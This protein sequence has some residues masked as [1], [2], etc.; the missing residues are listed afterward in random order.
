MVAFLKNFVCLG[1]IILALLGIGRVKDE[2]NFS[3]NRWMSLL[4]DDAYISEITIPGTHDTCALYEPWS[5]VVKCQTYSLRD[6]L[7]MGVRFLDIRGRVNFSKINIYH[8]ITYQCIDFKKVAKVCAEFLA[9]NPG[10]TIIMSIKSEGEAS[11]KFGELIDSAI[12]SQPDIWYLENRLPTLGEVRGKIVLFNRYTGD[13]EKGLY[14]Y[15][16]NS[17]P[18]ETI[19]NGSYSIHIQDN[20]S[21]SENS[22]KWE[23]MTAMYEESK[24]NADSENL[25]INF[26]SGVNNTD[27][28]IIAFKEYINPKLC[29]YFSAAEPA[30]YGVVIMD[31]ATPEMCKLMLEK[32]F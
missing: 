18:A 32:N 8:G 9:D 25:Y 24:K 10:E 23:N 11:E 15:G 16:W 31:Y 17:G 7:D 6:Q 12:K 26:S 22:V 2:G 21:V 13:T 4:P 1:T 19:D 5:G 3:E 14:A 29:D 28:D 30:C 20:Y 27:P